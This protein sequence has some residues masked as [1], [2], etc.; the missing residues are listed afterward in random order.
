MRNALSPF[1]VTWPPRPPQR[2]SARR[3]KNGARGARARGDPAGASA[4]ARSTPNN[5][6]GK[7]QGT[8]GD[9]VLGAATLERRLADLLELLAAGAPL[10]DRLRLKK[11]AEEARSHAQELDASAITL[12]RTDYA[13]GVQNDPVALAELLT[14][15]YLEAADKL[16]D[17]EALGR[18]QA[19]A[20]R[21]IARLAWMKVGPADS[22]PGDQGSS[23]FWRPGSNCCGKYD[24]G[25]LTMNASFQGGL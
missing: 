23:R 25:G 5:P 2:D 24:E 1:G 21:S 10:A 6:L 20:E 4:A 15:R 3:R 16:M 11:F 8:P 9:A 19:L 22:Y 14:D 13:R 18:V 12:P 7:D 17:E